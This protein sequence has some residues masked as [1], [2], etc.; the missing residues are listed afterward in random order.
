MTQI[1]N[2]IPLLPN[3]PYLSA[4]VPSISG[5][6]KYQPEDFVVEEVPQYLPSGGGDHVYFMIE[7]KGMTTLDLIRRLSQS[8]GRREKDFGYAGLKDAQAVTRQ[9]FSLEHANPEQIQSLEIKDIKIS[10]VDR[11][12][13]KIKLGHLKGNKFQIKLRNVPR[14]SRSGI[15]DCL[16]VLLK[17]GVPNYFGPQRFGMRSDNWI[18]G[19]AILQEDHQGFLSQFCG[20]AIPSDRDHVKKARDLFDKGQYELSAHVWPGFFRDAK[21][22]CSLLSAKPDNF[23]RAADAVDRKLKKLFVSAYQSMLFNEAMAKRIETLDRVMSGDLAMREDNG[24]VFKVLDETIEQPRAEKFEISPTGPLFGYRM[25]QP[26]GVEGE[27]E[28][29]IL[30]EQNITAEDFKKAA[31]H[32]VRG[33]RRPFRVRMTDLEIIEGQDNAGDFTQLNFYL[34]SGSYATAVLRE[35]MKSHFTGNVSS[36]IREE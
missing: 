23:K 24:A 32:K 10:S 15:E 28:S 12:S 19:R 6:V 35:L 27:T 29:A 14:G 11:H 18:L 16:A 8:L 20:R 2:K 30:R 25:I 34:P 7:K 17:R 21:R 1:N 9:M 36:A 4:E 26:E 13:N 3:W 33:S 5:T 31:G 22:A